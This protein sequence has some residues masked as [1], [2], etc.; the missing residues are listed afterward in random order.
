[1]VRAAVPDPNNFMGRPPQFGGGYL[2]KRNQF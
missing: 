2:Q 1:L